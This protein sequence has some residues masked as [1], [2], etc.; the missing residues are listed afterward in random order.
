[1]DPLTTIASKIDQDKLIARGITKCQL[2][3]NATMQPR[4]IVEFEGSQPNQLINGHYSIERFLKE[5]V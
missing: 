5:L 1:M 2:M 4:L 3:Q